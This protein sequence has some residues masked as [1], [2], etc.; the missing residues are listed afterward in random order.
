MEDTDDQP[1]PIL[2]LKRA[3][4][5]C[6]F[7]CNDSD[8]QLNSPQDHASWERLLKAAE[9]RKHPGI[10]KIAATARGTEIPHILYHKRCRSLFVR[11]RDLDAIEIGKSAKPDEPAASKELNRRQSSVGVTASSSRVYEP[12]CIFCMKTSKYLANSNTRES[13]VQCVELR[14]D[15]TVRQ[16]AVEKGDSSMIAITSRDLVAAEGHNQVL[17]SAIYEDHQQSISR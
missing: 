12:V 7:E 6:I 13:L 4:T 17:L 16:A 1:A 14:S 11:K 15:K 2:P 3:R 9:I 8:P 5:T 10:L